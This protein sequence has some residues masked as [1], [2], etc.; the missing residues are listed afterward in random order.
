M[1]RQMLHF[2]DGSEEL[3]GLIEGML[4]EHHWNLRSYSDLVMTS[5]LN[6]LMILLIYSLLIFPVIQRS[7]CNPLNRFGSQI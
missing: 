7:R 4:Q 2:L 1:I 6:S 3:K 5:F